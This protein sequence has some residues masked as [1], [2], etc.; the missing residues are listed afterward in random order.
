GQHGAGGDDG[1]I[2]DALTDPV[3]EAAAEPVS[4][5][6]L[7]AKYQV[8]DD[9]LKIYL[10]GSYY[11]SERGE[12]CIFEPAA[13]GKERCLPIGSG[14]TAGTYFL[15]PSCTQ[16]VALAFAGCVTKYAYT[17]EQSACSLMFGKIHIYPTGAPLQPAQVYHKSGASC[18]GTAPP[19]N[20]TLL[21]VGAEVP[22][23][24]FV[25]GSVQHD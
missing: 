5:S 17:V 19:E 10:P 23:S 20:F 24:S 25:A 2:F 13:D 12:D 16:D 1:G 6:R 3:P 18:V 14:A 15:D 7:K 9:G 11:D 21:S 22:A 4:G 8:S